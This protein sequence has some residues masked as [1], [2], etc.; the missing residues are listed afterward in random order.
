MTREEQGFITKRID[1]IKE[2]CYNKFMEKIKNFVIKYQLWIKLVA[3]ALLV[4]V[5]FTPLERH[6]SIFN[7]IQ[8]DIRVNDYAH[9]YSYYGIF[10]W[11]VFIL[12]LSLIVLMIVSIF[13]KNKNILLT[14]SVLYIIDFI[15]IF[16]T[17]LFCFIDFY[18]IIKYITTVGGTHWGGPHSTYPN[19]ASFLSLILVVADLMILIPLIK[20]K[21]QQPR[22]KTNKQKIAELEQR[23]IELEKGGN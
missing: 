15:F 6:S 1:I 18:Y 13:I 17:I 9:K 8:A 22:K 20:W 14:I 2:K 7:I 11:F 12:T 19:I 4:C 3:I 5:I 10:S 23:I 16:L 21:K